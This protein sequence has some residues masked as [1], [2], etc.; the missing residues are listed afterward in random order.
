MELRTVKISE[1]KGKS[2]S[3]LYQKMVEN[4]GEWQVKILENKGK[5]VNLKEG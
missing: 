2:W 1:N 3:S 4:G 5:L